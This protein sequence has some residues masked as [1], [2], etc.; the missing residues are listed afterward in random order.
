MIRYLRLKDLKS[1]TVKPTSPE[2]EDVLETAATGNT[3]SIFV[4]FYMS[5]NFEYVLSEKGYK[6]H[7][8]EYSQ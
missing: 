7:S 2:D 1:K 6:I 8:S 5:F 4:F 3:H